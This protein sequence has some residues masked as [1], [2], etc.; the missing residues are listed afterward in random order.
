MN[1]FFPINIGGG[2]GG[3]TGPS[4]IPPA[5]SPVK[6]ISSM[7]G[8]MMHCMTGRVPNFICVHLQK[9]ESITHH[10]QELIVLP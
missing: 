2:Q 5:T 7:I 10:L 8:I 3:A 1:R 4:P 6:M 9:I